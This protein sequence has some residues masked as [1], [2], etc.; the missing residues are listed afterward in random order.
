MVI[1]STKDAAYA[2]FSS[3][4]SLT[5][6]KKTP[7]I[8]FALT[9]VCFALLAKQVFTK[10]LLVLRDAIFFRVNLYESVFRIIHGLVDQLGDD[11]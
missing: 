10:P 11:V 2:L 7:N 5:S 1:E 6:V 9:Q 4:K 8:V 3:V